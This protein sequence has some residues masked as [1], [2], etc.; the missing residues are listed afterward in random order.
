M[1]LP[2]PP[3][4]LVASTRV[5]AAPARQARYASRHNDAWLDSVD[6][7]NRWTVYGRTGAASGPPSLPEQPTGREH[8][9]EPKRRS[10]WSTPMRVPPSSGTAPWVQRVDVSIYQEMRFSEWRHPRPR[11][12]PHVDASEALRAPSRAQRQAGTPPAGSPAAR[13]TAT[14]VPLRTGPGMPLLLYCHRASGQWPLRRES[15]KPLIIR[16]D[17]GTALSL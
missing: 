10:W 13:I 8:G 11:Q 7:A 12:A 3:V 1:S 6:R 14:S 17:T 2:V 9:P 5:E 16:G 4:P 15:P